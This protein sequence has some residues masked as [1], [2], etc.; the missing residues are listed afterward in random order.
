MLATKI[1]QAFPCI[2]FQVTFCS[3]S[4][5]LMCTLVVTMTKMGCTHCGGSKDNRITWEPSEKVNQ[6]FCVS[7]THPV[8]VG[9]HFTGRGEGR[10]KRRDKNETS[11][12]MPPA[13]LPLWEV[14]TL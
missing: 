9:D 3:M 6:I 14:A 5:Y 7:S 12:Q 4:D 8:A 13:H 2:A 1:K 10:R 11:Q